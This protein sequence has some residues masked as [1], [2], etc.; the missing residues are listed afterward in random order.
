MTSLLLSKIIYCCLKV[1]KPTSKL[2]SEIEIQEN[3]VLSTHS[4]I[5]ILLCHIIQTNS[6]SSLILVTS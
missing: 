4:K 5:H 3:K 2:V 1:N 6:A